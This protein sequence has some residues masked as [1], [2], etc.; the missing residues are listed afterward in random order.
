MNFDP[1]TDET[2]LSQEDSNE[3]H[4]LDAEELAFFKSQ[5]GITDD[6][7]LNRHVEQVQADA[8]KVYQYSCILKFRFMKFKISRLPV[9]AQLLKMGRERR[10]VI[11]LDIG[12]CFGNDVRKAVADGFPVESVI[13]SDLHAEF[14]QLGHRLFNSSADT[15]PVPFVAGDAFDETFLRAT[16]P[17][18]TP[19]KEPA[20]PLSSLTN[21]TP[22]LGHVSAIHASSF[23]HLFDEAR[24]SQLAK[25]L[26]GLLSPLPG[27][28][29][30]GAHGGLPEKGVRIREGNPSRAGSHMFCHSPESWGELWDGQVFER[31]TVKVEAKVEARERV[32]SDGGNATSYTLI[33]SVTRL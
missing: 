1:K 15:F 11:F 28:M 25:S 23:F 17:F 3:R 14:W 16:P 24:Q 33:W 8:Y 9:Y 4:K 21:L 27:S 2:S 19:P 5:T 30:F 26:A 29:I 32:T 7:A 22:L 31:G 18:Y 6:D 20:P 12:C 10:G 13:A